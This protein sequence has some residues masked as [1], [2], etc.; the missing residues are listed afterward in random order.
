MPLQP[1]SLVAAGHESHTLRARP[2][3][4]NQTTGGVGGEGDTSRPEVRVV[5]QV[6]EGHGVVRT[7]E[8]TVLSDWMVA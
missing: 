4:V 6:P 3:E 1:G 5:L 7:G 8:V 2:G